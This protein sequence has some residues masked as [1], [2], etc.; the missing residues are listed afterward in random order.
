M[1]DPKSIKQLSMTPRAAVLA[2]LCGFALQ[3]PLAAAAELTEQEMKLGRILFLQCRAC[4]SLTPKDNEGKIGPSLAGVYGRAAGSADYYE[5]YS[6][7]LRESA[8]E[9]NPET[10]SQW[11]QGPAA[12]VPGTTMVFAGLED[13]GRRDLLVRYLEVLTQAEA[14]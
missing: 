10:M 6:A 14:Q 13:A 12:M 11:L 5:N 9:W 8:H 2:L 1:I 3:L 4:H 7:A